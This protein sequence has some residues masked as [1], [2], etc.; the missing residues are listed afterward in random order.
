MP[1]A[2]CR[3]I[4]LM[5]NRIFAQKRGVSVGKTFV[6]KVLCDHAAEIAQL[7]DR[8]K[9]RIPESMPVNKVW[10]V[11]LTEI[12]DTNGKAKTV[13]GILDHGSR[14][15][16]TLRSIANKTSLTFAKALIAAIEL[17]GKP[18]A[19]RTD[20]ESCLNSRLFNVVLFILGI[21]HQ[22]TLP[23]CPWMNG[24]IE[25]FFGA[26]K[27]FADQ[28]LFSASKIQVA[29]DEFALWYNHIRPHQ[30]LGGRTPDEVWNHVDPFAQPP[31]SCRKFSAWDGLLTGYAVDYG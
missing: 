20:N 5:F 9:H 12:Q 21:R 29:L 1:Q 17:Y 3:T 7:R 13:L 27:Q 31:K 8:W 11:D 25:R 16:V 26:F 28:I 6:Y 18:K 22:R 24:R 30:H 14:K 19:I 4:A 15:C 2:G 10:G 23:H